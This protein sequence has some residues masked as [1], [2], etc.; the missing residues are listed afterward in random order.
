MSD[1]VATAT[2]T[3]GD[4]VYVTAQRFRTVYRA[5]A[6]ADTVYR[7]R[8]DTVRTERADTVT[9]TNTI[10]CQR[11]HMGWRSAIAALAIALI[12]AT[13]GAWAVWKRKRQ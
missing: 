6:K 3:R 10:I 7:T 1:S 13:A 8:T 9:V 4:T 11:R 2:T 12:A 5:K